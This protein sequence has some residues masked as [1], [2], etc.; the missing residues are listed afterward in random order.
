[1]PPS[2][3]TNPQSADAARTPRYGSRAVTRGIEVVV[4]PTYLHDKSDPDTSQ[5][6][7]MYRITIRNHGPEPVQLLSRR[8]LITDAHG[9]ASTVQGDGV[10]GQQ[11]R[12]ETGGAF[13]Y[14]SFCPL[15]TRWGTMEGSYTFTTEG[16]EPIQAAIA[17][18]YLV[19]S[20]QPSGAAV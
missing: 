4:Q 19:S 17:R 5:Y 8:W 7:F 1:M 18:F 6:V 12:L 2:D 16:G 14:Q 3:P 11:P 10:V 20:P 15:A 9:R 13:V